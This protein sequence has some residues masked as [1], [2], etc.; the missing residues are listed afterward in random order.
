M[1]KAGGGW[2]EGEI[3]VISDPMD[4]A[5]LPAKVGKETYGAGYLFF[6]FSGHG[7][8]DEDVVKLGVQGDRLPAAD[9]IAACHAE[10]ATFIFDCCRKYA[11][12][13][14]VDLLPL[15]KEAEAAEEI[16]QAGSRTAFEASLMLS[17]PEKTCCFACRSGEEAIDTPS[18]GLFST[19]LL[20]T[21]YRMA[22]SIGGGVTANL[23]QVVNQCSGDVVN[24]SRAMQNPSWENCLFPFVVGLRRHPV[25]LFE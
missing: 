24:G 12:V 5:Y 4:P 17:S 21:A 3:C 10:K 7:I 20:K 2:H 11:D 9:V 25:A 16:D 13:P 8:T 23:H 18:G 15:I 1:S 6:M 22:S 14:S 19:C